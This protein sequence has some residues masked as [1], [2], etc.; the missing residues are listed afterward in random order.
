MRANTEQVFIGQVVLYR[1]GQK[2]API[3]F[4]NFRRMPLTEEE[5]ERVARLCGPDTFKIHY[6]NANG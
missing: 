4:G 2:T 3:M 1:A 6:S 5:N